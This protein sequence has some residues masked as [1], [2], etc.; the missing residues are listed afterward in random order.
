MLGGSVWPGTDTNLGQAAAVWSAEL[1]L[2]DLSLN[3]DR[4]LLEHP[5]S[6]LGLSLTDW[7]R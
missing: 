3:E 7:V 2:E 5:L 1:S 6:L 4:C